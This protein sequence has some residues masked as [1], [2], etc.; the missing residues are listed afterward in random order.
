MSEKPLNLPKLSKILVENKIYNSID[1]RSLHSDIFLLTFLGLAPLCFLSVRSWTI[2]FTL[3]IVLISIWKLFNMQ[4]DIIPQGNKV[5]IYSIITALASPIIAVTMGQ[6]FRGDWQLR[7]MDG[8]ARPLLSIFIFI[9]LLHKSIDFVKLLEWCVPFSLLILGGLLLV[10]PY[11]WANMTS[12]RF[13]TTA[14]DPLTLG[15]YSTL[16]AFICLFTLNLYGKDGWVLKTL[17]LMGIA[18]GLWISIGAGSRS[19]WIAIP[20]L[21]TLWIIHGLKIRQPKIIAT[22]FLIIMAIGFLIYEISPLVH[23]RINLT[24][25]EYSAYIKNSNRDTSAGLRLSMLRA[26]VFLFFENPIAGYG[27]E[28][29]PKLSNVFGIASF[30]TEALEQAIIENGVHNEIMQNALR[31]G[32]FGVISSL[33]MFFVPAVIFYRG[34]NS[35]NPSIRAAGLIGLC[36][37]I[38]VFLF[39][40]STE[41]FNLKYTI[42]FYA[43]MVS[44]LAAQV[45]RPQST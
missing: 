7:L 4:G 15:Q 28:N 30:N 37:I 6:I 33:L 35:K 25:A 19:A 14:V 8:P 29:Y 9:Y 11:E 32:I 40:L 45:L 36:Y 31:S 44:A 43:L 20:F 22:S 10:H 41:T 39:G 12:E 1:H 17:K 23:N 3:L 18:V 5:F 26:A 21:T 27:D 42:T 34:S 2:L 38:S 24:Y 13:G 16:L